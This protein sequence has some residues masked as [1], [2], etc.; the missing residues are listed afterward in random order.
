MFVYSF[1]EL[2][3]NF[4]AELAGKFFDDYSKSF[5]REHEVDLRSLQN[6]RHPEHMEANA[7]A[8]IYWSNKY[9]LT[10]THAA[11]ISL[12]QFLENKEREG[13]SV[14]NSILQ[15]HLNIVTV[16][17]TSVGAERSLAAI[18][19]RNENDADLPDEDEGIPGHNPGSANTDPK[20]PPV[21]TRLNLGPLPMEAEMSVDVREE[22]EEE[23]VKN[24]AAAGR[25]SLVEEFD[26]QIKREPSEDAPNR[27]NLPLPKPLA[28]DVA[29]EVQ[30]IKENRDRFRILETREGG[31]GPG[32][33]VTMFTFHNTFDRYV[34]D[35]S[36]HV[37]C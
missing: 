13:G 36:R 29:M 7:T 33:S 9:R 25:P 2:V 17:R 8:K 37:A 10:L 15:A 3:D 5:S 18:I 27:D 31:I 16:D 11:F 4:Y 20:A 19:A 32:V 6:V 34:V 30:R 22:L 14:I 28:R 1:L 23:D 12:I 24:P 21:L 26:Q 35:E